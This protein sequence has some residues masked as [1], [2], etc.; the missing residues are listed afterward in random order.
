M[1]AGLCLLRLDAGSFWA[2]TPRELHA[3]TGGLTP[4]TGAPDRGAL[5]ALM[6]RFPDKPERI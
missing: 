5:A 6:R 3:A 2:M 1:H 4:D